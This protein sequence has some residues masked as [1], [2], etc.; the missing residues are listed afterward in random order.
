[1]DALRASAATLQALWSQIP[2]FLKLDILDILRSNDLT[3][4]DKTAAMEAAIPCKT[5]DAFIPYNPLLKPARDEA[6][7]AIDALLYK[8][9]ISTLNFPCVFCKS[10]NTIV[11]SRQTRSADEATPVSIICLDCSKTSTE[12][13]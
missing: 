2:S 11:V 6:A 8:P 1:M 13:G 7:D 5:Q 10:K 4:A 12:R 3:E 9:E